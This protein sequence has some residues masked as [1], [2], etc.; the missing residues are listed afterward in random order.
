[1]SGVLRLDWRGSTEEPV[2]EPGPRKR[3]STVKSLPLF[4]EYFVRREGKSSVI[5]GIPREIFPGVRRL[6]LAPAALPALVKA[7][8]EAIVETGDRS[9]NREAGSGEPA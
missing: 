6:P 1:M 2:E 8:C 9:G 5:I 4:P 7:G 3:R